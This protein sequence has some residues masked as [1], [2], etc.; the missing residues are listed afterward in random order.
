M[1][2]LFLLV[3][4]FALNAFI[5]DAPTISKKERKSAAK[6]LKESEDETLKTIGKLSEAQLKFKPAPDKWSVEECMMHIAA[7]EKMLWGMTEGVINAPANPEKRA[8]IKMTDE[9]VMKNIEDRTTKRKTLPPLEPQNT[10]FK[11]LG[12]AVASFTEN[13]EKLISYTKDTKADLRNHV[14]TLPSGSFDCYQMILFIGA[15]TIRHVKQME[16][17]MADPGFPKN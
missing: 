6:F 10:G 1:K 13:R 9:E 2:I 7:S 3:S 12:E 11:S 4:F 14:N 8:E 15:H 5:A 16:E 17:V